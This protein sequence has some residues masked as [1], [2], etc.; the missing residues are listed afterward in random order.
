MLKDQTTNTAL[1]WPLKLARMAGALLL[2]VG[3][4]GLLW[5]LLEF[6]LLYL[7]PERILPLTR[8]IDSVGAL[9]AA[10]MGAGAGAA[11]PM[12]VANFLAWALAI[13]LLAMLGRV[14][15]WAIRAGAS[16]LAIPLPPSPA[17]PTAPA[18]DEA[19]YGLPR[20]YQPSH[21]APRG[22]VPSIRAPSRGGNR[23]A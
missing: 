13:V 10:L 19:D 8:A 15:Y 22:D 1:P 7:N 23:R 3:I 12:P 17:L 18:A 6:W 20:D 16:L 21:R 2:L 5:A 11:R 14:A 4:A 9:D